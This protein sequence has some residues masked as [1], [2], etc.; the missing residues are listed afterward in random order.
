MYQPTSFGLLN[1]LFA[2]SLILTLLATL[3]PAHVAQAQIN[4]QIPFE[5]SLRDSVGTVLSGPYDMTFDLFDAATAGAN[6]WTGTHTAANGN[7]VTVTNGVF[8]VLLGSGAGNDLTGVNFNTP[9]LYLEVTVAGETMSP[10]YR[11]GAAAYAFNADTLDGFDASD[12]ALAGSSTVTNNFVSETNFNATSTF[13]GDTTFASSTTFNDSS[14]FNGTTTFT[15]GLVIDPGV[16]APTTNTLYNNGGSLFWNGAEVG[17]VVNLLN[18]VGNVDAATTTGSLLYWNGTA[19]DDIATSSLNIPGTLTSISTTT[20]SFTYT[21]ENGDDT[22][23]NFSEAETLT[24]LLDQAAASG[25]IQYIDEAGAT[26]TIDIS[27]LPDLTITGDATVGGELG[28]TGTTTSGILVITGDSTLG[29]ALS[30]AGESLLSGNVAIGTDTTSANPLTVDGAVTLN[31]TTT[32]NSA[33]NAIYN[34]NGT[35]FWNGLQVL[36]SATST[37]SDFSVELDGTG[38]YAVRPSFDAGLAIATELTIAAWVKYPSTGSLTGEHVIVSFSDGGEASADNF[39]YQLKMQD[40]TGTNDLAELVYFHEYGSGS[41]ISLDSPG[42]QIAND[43]WMHVALTR[44]TQGGN[45]AVTFYVNGTELGSATISDLPT[46]GGDG[47]FS[48][49]A[50]EDGGDDLEGSLDDVRIYNRNLTGAEIGA[51]YNSGQGQLTSVITDGLTAWYP[52]RDNATPGILEDASGN[53]YDMS[54]LGNAAKVQES[55]VID[56]SFGGLYIGT[57]D[58]GITGQAT[59][60]GADGAGV[61]GTSDLFFNNGTVNVGTT[62]VDQ[63]VLN[64]DGGIFLASTTPTNTTDA[65]YNNAGTL[66]FNGEEIAVA[67][68]LVDNQPLL[69]DHTEQVFEWQNA[70]NPINLRNG[71]FKLTDDPTSAVH[72]ERV[73]MEDNTT[74]R[75]YLFGPGSDGSN[76]TFTN[77]SV[78]AAIDVT[79]TN[80][81]LSYTV[82]QSNFLNHGSDAQPFYAGLTF[83]DIVSGGGPVILTQEQFEFYV[84]ESVTVVVPIAVDID[85]Y[86]VFDNWTTSGIEVLPYRGAEGV[87]VVLNDINGSNSIISNPVPFTVTEDTFSL[88]IELK[89]ETT[90]KPMLVDLRDNTFALNRASINPTDG[91][92]S[93]TDGTVSA[94]E[95]LDSWVFK[96]DYDVTGDPNPFTVNILPDFGAGEDSN[97]VFEFTPFVERTADIQQLGGASSTT[98]GTLGFVAGAEAGE[99]GSFLLGNGEWSATSTLF[100]DT[101]NNKLELGGSLVLASTTPATT[102]DALYNNGGTLYFDGSEVGAITTAL[103][104]TYNETAYEIGSAG[105]SFVD[106]PSFTTGDDTEIVVTHSAVFGSTNAYFTIGTTAGTEDDGV[107]SLS[108]SATRVNPT[109]PEKTYT[110]TLL[111]NT[112]YFVRVGRGGAGNHNS[113]TVKIETKTTGDIDLTNQDSVT[114]ILQVNSTQTTGPTTNGGGG[115]GPAS[116]DLS[117]T[118]T[119]DYTGLATVKHTS[120]VTAGS[121]FLE[122]GTAVGLDDVFTATN[123]R[124]STTETERTYTFPVTAGVPYFTR[125]LSSGLGAST[126]HTVTFFDRREGDVEINASTGGGLAQNGTLPAAVVEQG[127]YIAEGTN[128]AVTLYAAVGS[129]DRVMVTSQAA[130]VGTI[131]GVQSGESLNGQ[132]DGTYTTQSDGEVVLFIDNGVGEWTV[133]VLGAGEV[134]DLE[135][136][137]QIAEFAFL[138][139]NGMQQG[140]NSYLRTQNGIVNTIIDTGTGITFNGGTVGNAFQIPAGTWRIEVETKDSSNSTQFLPN[141]WRFDAAFNTSNSN[142]DQLD[143]K[144]TRHAYPSGTTRVNRIERIFTFSAPV[145]ANAFY[146]GTNGGSP[147]DVIVRFERLDVTGQEVVLAGMVEVESLDIAQ[148]GITAATAGVT[149]GDQSANGGLGSPLPLFGFEQVQGSGIT[150]TTSAELFEVANAGTYELNWFY[151]AVNHSYDYHWKITVDG[152]VVETLPVNYNGSVSSQ[153]SHLVPNVPA[154]STIGL[155]WFSDNATGDSVNF[156]TD[157]SDPNA[158]YVRLSRVPVATVVNPGDIDVDTT[159]GAIAFGDGSDLSA[160]AANLYWDAANNGLAIGTSTVQQEA[161]LTLGPTQNNTATE[162]GQVTFLSGTAHNSSYAIDNHAGNL[163]IIGGDGSGAS[164]RTVLSMASSTDTLILGVSSAQDYDH[165]NIANNSLVLDNGALCVDNGGLNCD[166]AARVAGT[167]Y[168]VGAD[169]TGI[170]LAES[171]PSNDTTLLPGELLVIDPSQPSFVARSGETDGNEVLLGIVSTRPGVLLGGFGAERFGGAHQ[172]AVALAGRVPVLFSA[173]NGPVAAGD[174]LIASASQPGYAMAACGDVFCGEARAVAV[175]LESFGENQSG[176]TDLVA[177][178]LVEEAAEIEEA[179]EDIADNTNRLEATAEAVSEEIEEAVAEGDLS[180]MSELAAVAEEVN[181][182]L[183]EAIAIE[184]E[185]GD[186]EEVAEELTEEITTVTGEGRLMAFVELAD[187]RGA[188]ATTETPTGFLAFLGNAA[189]SVG[190][191]V[192]RQV[193]AVVGFFDTIF[194]R[195]VRT[196]TLCIGNTCVDEDA[197]EALLEDNDV[198]PVEVV[199]AEQPEV[200]EPEPVEV[201]ETSTDEEDV[202]LADAVTEDVAETESIESEAEEPLVEEAEVAE[203][204]VP[205]VEEEVVTDPSEEVIEADVDAVT[206]EIVEEVVITEEVDEVVEVE[207]TEEAVEETT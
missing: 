74:K 112:T 41:N 68:D 154:G 158:G 164:N 114:S 203:T 50:N 3:I 26:T 182:E 28:V 11:L 88:D 145:E 101:D 10:R 121:A 191:F 71:F 73:S 79:A 54:L 72:S 149:M 91:T 162:G 161:S 76:Q 1:R 43:R 77:F 180:E 18:D 127:M 165:S 151:T 172:A 107:G 185:A 35:L 183:I 63:N 197:L 75:F 29:G 65:L 37:A 64:V 205:A 184:D 92:S 130:G 175:A 160:D 134:R 19:W 124:L 132:T 177:A 189:D 174:K 111:P 108:V 40:E 117:N 193:S 125:V 133:Q 36:T 32:P 66:F 85:L 152:T 93:I 38:D 171:Y 122:V 157:I 153:Y 148:Y 95:T 25:T 2:V 167:I 62:T 81:N 4:P 22:V 147:G 190:D 48:V 100:L 169:V 97:T 128:S 31:S 103:V 139:T 9:S 176:D 109:T 166:D 96:I 30:V 45:G 141:Q 42:V 201:V 8:Q 52:I 181:E 51:I 87:G 106:L 129:Q 144:N 163:R 24:Q 207:V 61:E 55:V 80:G 67:S 104:E 168:S 82:T 195:E 17:G 15:N 59:Y 70:S 47:R 118:V 131:I 58:T 196:E 186:L 83:G 120:D 14:T 198:E 99:Q 126:N 138:N 143:F 5:G 98:A 150:S 46:G 200:T 56:N 173:E 20:G 113:A 49:G 155:Y 170:D 110:A 27:T 137:N 23:V 21:D 84:A 192:S 159:V 202:D 34:D 7:G 140:I 6:L 57:I 90:N 86:Q 94:V 142:T 78:G 12:F 123:G 136:S 116:I 105:P 102:T 188:D 16:P 146:T 33:N 115:S 13:G 178:E 156:D 89:K 194:A 39:L 119:F 187:V 135:N 204:E 199:P 44:T 60:Y 206:E 179:I 53:G 69:T